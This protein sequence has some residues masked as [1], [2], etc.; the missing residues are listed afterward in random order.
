M[1]EESEIRQLIDQSNK[2]SYAGQLRRLKFLLSIEE[3][4]PFPVSALAREYYEEAR[5]CWYVGAFVSTII[6]TQLAFEELFRAHYRSAYGVGGELD[7][8]KKVDD[9][10]FFDL[11]QQARMDSW[12][13]DEEEDL[14]NDLRK[15]LR[16][17]Y[18]HVKDV[19]LTDE[20]KKGQ[21]KPD[22]FIQFLKIK[23]SKHIEVK[24]EDEAG[25]AIQ[26]LAILFPS[27]SERCGGI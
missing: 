11:I 8:G 19:S 23:G 7:C 3:Q 27:I 21:Q 22:F 10:S 6:M 13:S 16:N 17:P 25:K 1:M 2:I 14:L 12:I 18:V 26:L 20:K 5:L 15:N 4:K 24:T 9:A